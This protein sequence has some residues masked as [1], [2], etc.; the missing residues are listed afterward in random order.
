MV[1]YVGVRLHNKINILEGLYGKVHLYCDLTYSV[2][3]Y[4]HMLFPMTDFVKE[5]WPI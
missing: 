3:D 4:R 5:K 2:E 1:E